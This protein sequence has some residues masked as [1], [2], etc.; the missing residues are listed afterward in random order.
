LFS[1]SGL[2]LEL[3]GLFPC[4]VS[5]IA[6]EVSISSGLLV[7]RAGELEVTD[8]ASRAEIEVVEDDR[9]E[10]RV[11]LSSLDSAIGIN[12]HGEG[13]GDSDGIGDLDQA[14]ASELRGNEGLS[15]PTN[16]VSGRAIDLGG[17]LSG[18]STA[19]MGTPTSIGINDDLATSETSISV[20]ASNDEAA[21]GVQVVDGLKTAQTQNKKRRESDTD[22]VG[23][24]TAALR[25]AEPS[26]SSGCCRNAGAML[27]NRL[28]VL[29]CHPSTWQAR[30]AKQQHDRAKT[31]NQQQVSNQRDNLGLPVLVCELYR[32]KQIRRVPHHCQLPHSGSVFCCV[33]FDSYLDDVLHEILCD[34]LVGDSLIVLG[35]DHHSVDA[36]GDHGTVLLLVLNDNLSLAIGADP[37]KP[38]KRRKKERKVR[39]L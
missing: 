15:D 34:L 28:F 12:E 6:S 13:L 35:G 17:V 7:D 10:I 2:I 21:R 9:K 1:Q 5:I 14:A 23:I 4:E 19:S 25:T 22:H 27:N 3:L 29:P 11:G 33:S 24:Q 30:R 8:D 36:E 16:S 18:E 39:E 20:R 37:N 32:R 31:A 38:H 26:A